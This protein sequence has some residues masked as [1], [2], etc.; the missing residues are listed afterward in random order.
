VRPGLLQK[1]KK[2]NL[3]G[4]KKDLREI[5]GPRFVNGVRKIKYNDE[6]LQLVQRA[7]HSEND[8]ESLIEMARTR[9]GYRIMCP[10]RR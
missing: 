6:M 2:G 10:A 4:I 1:L 7:K 9:R 5:Y 3:A 8:Y